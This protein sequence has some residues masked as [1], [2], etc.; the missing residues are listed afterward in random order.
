MYADYFF[1]NDFILVLLQEIFKTVWKV[2]L[3]EVNEGMV[4]K[5]KKP[6]GIGFEK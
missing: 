3:S 2:S 5:T 1:I 6:S 4:D